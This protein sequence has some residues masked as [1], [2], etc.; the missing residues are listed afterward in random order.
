MTEFNTSKYSFA[1]EN[2]RF[3]KPTSLIKVTQP[4]LLSYVTSISMQSGNTILN[5]FLLFDQ[6]LRFFI[7]LF[8]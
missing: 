5:I 2:Y 6:T 4:Q 3:F 7:Y 8:L 1:A